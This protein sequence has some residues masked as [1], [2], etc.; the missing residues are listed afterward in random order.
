MFSFIRRSFP[1]LVL[2]VIL[3]ISGC[4]P[5]SDGNNNQKDKAG[6][7]N[8]QEQ[9]FVLKASIQS[10][11]KAALSRGFDAYL[12]EIE[13]KSNGRITFERYYGESLAKAADQL[14]AL[15]NG[16]ADIA[17]FVPS[18]VPGKLPLANVGT[19]PALWHDSW[20]G[21]KSYHELYKTVPELQQ[22]LEK[23]N[24]KWVGQYAL[25]SYYIISTKKVEDFSDLKGLKVIATGQLAVLAEALGATPVG[26]PITESYEAMQRGTVDAVFYGLT[27][28]VTYGLEDSAKYIW[29]LPI[30]SSAG[31]IG[32]NLIT[33]NKLPKDLQQV[34]MDTAAKH[35]DA[36]HKIYQVEG[37]EEALQ[38]FVNAG[39]KIIEP[40]PEQVEKLKEMAKPI[41][42][43]WAQDM[44]SKGLPGQK[45]LDTFRELI[46]KYEQEN[47]YKSS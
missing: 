35:P 33:W 25:P 30:G 6:E 4:G 10:P 39:A 5:A 34:I 37:D 27:A 21:A 36:F 42:D 2:A 7:A 1:L 15:T 3:V 46:Q 14:N 24:V 31:L 44:E 12:D 26:I 11:P 38:K 47:P 20:V 43:K 23:E 28:S 22:E 29:K 18:Y 16:M 13:A 40:K 8:S 45:I 19:L 17:L 32:M 41:W 9:T